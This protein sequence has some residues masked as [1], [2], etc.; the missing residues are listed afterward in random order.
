MLTYEYGSTS[1][2]RL[3]VKLTIQC[4]RQQQ[5]SPCYLLRSHTL[6]HTPPYPI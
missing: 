2:S 1:S 6:G 5:R 3:S 4:F